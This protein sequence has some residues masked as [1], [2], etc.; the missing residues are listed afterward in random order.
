MI[1]AFCAEWYQKTGHGILIVFAAVGG[2]EIQKFLPVSDPL[3]LDGPSG[4]YVYEYL[5]AAVSGAR[6]KAATEDILIAGS[7]FVSFQGGGKYAEF[8]L[9][10]G[11]RAGGFLPGGHGPFA[12]GPD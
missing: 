8:Q 5:A 11:V 7:Y 4:T 6:E 9:C 3:H 12:G 10:G 2:A 1:N